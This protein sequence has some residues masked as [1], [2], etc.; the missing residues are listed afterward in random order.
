MNSS[1]KEK[2]KKTKTKNAFVPLLDCQRKESHK[3]EADNPPHPTCEKTMLGEQQKRKRKKEIDNPASSKLVDA[4]QK[5]LFLKIFRFAKK[6][7]KKKTIGK[8]LLLKVLLNFVSNFIL[9]IEA[10]GFLISF[11]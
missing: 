11:F 2:T 3:D 4:V 8:N 1:S 6:R 7:K 5:L 9:S 10:L